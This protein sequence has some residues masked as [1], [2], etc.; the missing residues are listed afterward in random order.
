MK[1][2]DFIN[3]LQ[4]IYGWD[5]LPSER[6]IMILLAKTN[7]A[8]KILEEWKAFQEKFPGHS[9]SKF[10]KIWAVKYKIPIW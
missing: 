2:N 3:Q 7:G 9:V 5:L 10:A 1:P 4:I 8:G 6:E